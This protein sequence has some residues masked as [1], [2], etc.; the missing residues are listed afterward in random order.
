M[1]NVHQ[2]NIVVNDAI[3]SY[4]L[5]IKA[6]DTY[7]RLLSLCKRL[8]LTIFR[9]DFSIAEEN[10][11]SDYC[12]NAVCILHSVIGLDDLS[13]V[14]KD[15]LKFLNSANLKDCVD[16]NTITHL[17]NIKDISV[18]KFVLYRTVLILIKGIAP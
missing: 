8:P 10:L 2:L 15:Q 7:S 16:A 11:I 17:Q 6:S 5:T 4:L 18:S 13:L 12:Q 14:L 1:T 9:S 3:A